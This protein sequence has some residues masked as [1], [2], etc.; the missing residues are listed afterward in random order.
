MS[1]LLKIEDILRKEYAILPKKEKIDLDLDEQLFNKMANFLINL[2]PDDLS[3]EQTQE[4]IN[5]IDE[6]DGLDEERLANKTTLD[7]NQYSK[8][9]YSMNKMEIK[10]RKGKLERSSEGKKREKMKDKM[11]KVGKTPTGRNK[12]KYNRRIK[13][14]GD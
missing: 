11:E 4:I 13:G 3:Y 10:R 6:L 14:K 8:K 9:W 7:K 1:I 5:I 12:L 2:N